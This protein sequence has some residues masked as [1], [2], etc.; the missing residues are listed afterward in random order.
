MR[1]TIIFNV[2]IVIKDGIHR[3]YLLKVERRGF[4]VYCFLPHLGMHYSLHESGEA[5]FRPEG[6]AGKPG[7]EPPVVLLNGEAG[8][9]IYK[10]FMRKS[11]HE[12]GSA[13]GICT[14]VYPIGSLSHDFPKFNRSAGECFVIDTDSF[15]RG[16]NSVKVEVWAVPASNRASFEFNRPNIPAN[17]LYKKVAQ[18]DL[19]IWMYAEPF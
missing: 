8:R 3:Y 2:F 9:P 10:G 19:Q 16:T 11:L 13:C 1:E 18:D 6:K 5:Y 7:E 12:L 15:P 17:L 14:A 4:N